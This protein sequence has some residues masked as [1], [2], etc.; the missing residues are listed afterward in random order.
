MIVPLTI[1]ALAAGVGWFAA[2]RL[3]G[4][5]A[6]PPV[7][8]EPES[9]PVS[10]GDVVVL[11]GGGDLWLARSMSF[12]EGGGPAFLVLLEAHGA[13]EARVIACEPGRPNEIA[14]LHPITPAWAATS[15][16]RLP[17]TIE[18]EVEGAVERLA[19]DAR[20][21]ARGSRGALQVES[22]T[23][24][25]L[26]AEGEAQ[27]GT[28]RGG[29]RCFAVAVRDASRVHAWAGRLISVSSISILEG[30]R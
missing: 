28:Y 25:A 2:R 24:S 11:A 9:G 14:L 17:Q 29:A 20:R 6:P 30:G 21:V 15:M 8:P 3:R 7:E 26:P 10:L 19:L 18:A 16:T 1:A 4:R 5:R 12:S 13:S 27:V 23:G 22:E